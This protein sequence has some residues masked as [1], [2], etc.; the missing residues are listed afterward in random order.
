MQPRFTIPRLVDMIVPSPIFHSEVGKGVFS[1]GIIGSDLRG[2]KKNKTK[3]KGKIFEGEK[4][5]HAC[6]V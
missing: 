6:V 1:E 5:I 2:M 3:F 4:R